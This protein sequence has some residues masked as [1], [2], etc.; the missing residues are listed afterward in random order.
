MFVIGG[1]VASWLIA[2]AH[3]VDRPWL[4][5]ALALPAGLVLS[6]ALSAAINALT[7]LMFSGSATVGQIVASAAGGIGIAVVG[8]IAAAIVSGALVW[9][10][11][12]RVFDV[13][14]TG[15]PARTR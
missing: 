3:G 12:G 8:T 4:V 9:L 14:D 15:S 5:T 13:A 1:I 11:V 2:R 6:T 10:W 7:G